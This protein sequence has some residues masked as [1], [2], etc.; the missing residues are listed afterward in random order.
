MKVTDDLQIF[1]Q[2]WAVD[3][4]CDDENSDV[5]FKVN[6]HDDD[7]DDHSLEDDLDRRRKKTGRPSSVNS[8]ATIPSNA[9]TYFIQVSSPRVGSLITD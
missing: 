1:I 6:D 2:L 7:D 3:V 8:P 5:D 9:S 4:D